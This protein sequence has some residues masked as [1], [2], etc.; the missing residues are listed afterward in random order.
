MWIMQKYTPGC[1]V[2]FRI[3]F[4]ESSSIDRL[5]GFSSFSPYLFLWFMI[6]AIWRRKAEILRLTEYPLL[7]N[8]RKNCETA[9]PQNQIP[10]IPYWQFINQ[11]N[12][13]NSSR[14]ARVPQHHHHCPLDFIGSCRWTREAGWLSRLLIRNS[15][16]STH[17]VWVRV[18]NISWPFSHSKG[19]RLQCTDWM[20]PSL[21]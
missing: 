1:T 4:F 9:C 18:L 21:R 13:G 20:S 2:I 12:R 6:A 15:L 11:N 8:G 3:I 10:Q 17:P 16:I 7:L 5:I 19:S 14:D